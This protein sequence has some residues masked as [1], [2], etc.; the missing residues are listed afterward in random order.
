MWLR[1]KGRGC[2]SCTVQKGTLELRAKHI[3]RGLQECCRGGEVKHCRYAVLVSFVSESQAIARTIYLDYM[4]FVVHGRAFPQSLG[5]G[6]NAH[7]QMAFQTH[8]YYQN[9]SQLRLM[10]DS[11]SVQPFFPIRLNSS[12]AFGASLNIVR[13]TP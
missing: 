5:I 2:V 4:L 8:P 9:A 13:S 7:R 6:Q 10:L 1:R 3:F 11:I 12:S